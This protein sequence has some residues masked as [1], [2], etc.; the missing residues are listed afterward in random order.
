MSILVKEK[1]AN[2]Y[3]K[4]TETASNRM[5]NVDILSLTNEELLEKLRY[6][7]LVTVN[8]DILMRLQRDEHFYN[9][10]KQSEWVVCDSRIL[11]LAAKFLG[12]PFKEVIPG[13]SF[14]P[15]YYN[16]H[17]LNPQ[18]RIFLLGAQEGVAKK[19]AISINAKVGRQIV[20][21]SY[22]PPIGFEDN[23]I[24]CA[25]IVSKINSSTATVL[26]VGLGAPKQE[27]WIAMYRSR[28]YNV[29]VFMA[30]GATIDFEAGNIKRAPRIFQRL[31]LEWF[32]RLVTEP[33]RLWRRYLVDDLPIFKYIFRQKMGLYKNPFKK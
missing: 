15:L 16:Y 2:T 29:E 32:F 4:A 3:V 28:L 25:H 1:I 17:R 7:M 12:K 10:V 5:L 21:D 14:F 6:G 30:L 27:N 24:E 8:V 13:S 33:R 18:V 11:C 31:S 20:V 22:S 23:P 19:A 26:V 9:I